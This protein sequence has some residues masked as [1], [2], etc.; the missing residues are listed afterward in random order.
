MGGGGGGGRVA[1][2]G[3]LPLPIPDAYM[4]GY[5]LLACI[6]FTHH[7]YTLYNI[8]LHIIYN[9]I[10]YNRYIRNQYSYMLLASIF[11]YKL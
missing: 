11:A 8:I 7:I 2:S 4:N 1:G 3:Q 5:M 9:I 6:R 10:L